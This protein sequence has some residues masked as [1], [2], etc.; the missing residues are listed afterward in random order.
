MSFT[1]YDEF[2]DATSSEKTVLVKLEAAKRVVGWSVYSG[3]VYSISD[4]DFPIIDS[5][6]DSGVALTSVGSIGAV[7]AGK[8]FNDVVNKVIYLRTSDSVNPNGK[9]LVMHF[10][11]FYSNTGVAVAYDLDAGAEVEWLPLLFSTSE[12]GVELD[13][14]NQFGNAIEGSGKVD[15][16]NDQDYWSSRFDK[17]TFENKRCFVYSWNR[18]LPASESQLLFRG[19]V[20][21]KSWGLQRISFKLR[22]AFN[23]LNT[24]LDL[25]D[26]TSLVG[27][28]VP[29]SDAMSKLRRIY[30]YV[31][32][33]I[34]LNIDQVLPDTGYPL[35]GTFAVTSGSATITGTSI[36]F[37]YYFSPNDRIILS[38][39][40]EEIA[41]KSI[42]SSTSATL[43]ED[44][45]GSTATGLTA[46]IFPG[47]NKR[48]TNRIFQ[49]AG[50]ATREPTTTVAG[51]VG[52]RII[53]VVSSTDMLAGDP[54]IVNGEI[55]S[56]DRIV[57]NRIFLGQT[58]LNL[59]DVGDSVIRPSVSNVYLDSD[60]LVANR[61]Y[62]YNATNGKLTLDDEAEFNVAVIESI[63]GSITL[64][65]A[66]RSVTG[67]GS[68]F[69]T[70][71]Q[72]GDWIRTKGQQDFFEVLQI[73]SDTALEIRTASTYTATASGEVKH[74]NT[75]EE[76]RVTLS[77][78][79]MG[80][81]ENR[82]FS[83]T[84]IKTGPQIVKDLVSE[85]GAGDL[86]ET[87]S[88]TTASALAPFRIG[89]AIP[90][91]ATETDL[92]SIRDLI[93]EV[94]KSV[95]GSLVQNGDFELEYQIL[96]PRRPPDAR[97]IQQDEIISF[98]VQ[99]DSQRIA[100]T[101]KI[102]Y[103]KKEFDPNSLKDSFSQAVASS[104]EAEFIS[105]TSKEFELDTRLVDLR[106]AQIM[107]DRWAFL[108]SVS[109]G[110]IK[111]ETKI[112]TSDLMVTDIVRVVHEKI[113]ERIGSSTNEKYSAI[114]SSK[115]DGLSVSIETEDLSN[116][117]S[118]CATI[119]ETTSP[120]YSASTESQKILN[121]FVTDQYGMIAND[122]ETFG[123]NL[124]W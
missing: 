116:S 16:V 67:S 77:L 112:Q 86:I 48:Y 21:S 9:F 74:P 63:T 22:D 70:E 3:S 99:S 26:T 27:A 24:T 83:G 6:Q 4:F 124:I 10:W 53:D 79:C 55:T 7:T 101:A 39:D 81:T 69:T 31:F 72:P 13:N 11:N 15:L 87:T 85:A 5:I 103:L 62:T 37:L 30:G 33:L 107:A 2:K 73:T 58:L 117:F 43:T 122:P 119:T 97:Q 57:G 98:E 118:R 75:Y 51:S 96:S 111:V 23:E 56:I 82:T 123:V 109:S 34:P 115:K 89:I 18:Q 44:Y 84:F 42:Q 100:K 1:T 78:D 40:D 8:Y 90:E 36:N 91:N 120:N 92:P 46:R 35:P 47:H 52:L 76:G 95:F 49:V 19:R 38:Q 45:A 71:L 102:N 114:Q 25:E 80:I 104:R 93:S 20:Q 64:T 88:F 29:D 66:S 108:L 54:I 41:I 12:F 105:E 65:S 50:H 121:G 110:I 68:V 32:G 94:N 106:D 17:L 60:L 59:V 28:R 113:Y 14:Q 61:D